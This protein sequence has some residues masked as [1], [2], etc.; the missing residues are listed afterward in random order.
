M[1]GEFH[2]TEILEGYLSALY[3]LSHVDSYLR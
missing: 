3:I 1:A 2:V